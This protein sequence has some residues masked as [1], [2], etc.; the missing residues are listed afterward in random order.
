M[1]TPIRRVSGSTITV[2]DNATLMLDGATLTASGSTTS[3]P[4][5]RGV[6]VKGTGQ[7]PGATYR[8]VL[9]NNSALDHTLCASSLEDGPNGGTIVYLLDQSAFDHNITH[10]RDVAVHTTGTTSFIT[11]CTFDSDPAQT[12]FPYEQA[13]G[14]QYY[15]YQA[16][17]LTPLGD[18][19]S[20][21]VEVT[22]NPI[23]NAVY[24]IVNNDVDRAG[25]MI[26]NNMLAR[27]F[28][29]AIWTVN[30]DTDSGTLRAATR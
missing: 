22:G 14:S 26:R 27:I 8:L 24:G 13:G 28:Q 18:F 17:F 3:G 29:T 1:G 5:W 11:N 2:G 6:V 10:V 30:N 9:Q 15:A 20:H 16:L 25:V 12:R 7:G 23:N 19:G 4:M 21:A